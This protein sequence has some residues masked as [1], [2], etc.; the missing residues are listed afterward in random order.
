MNFFRTLCLA[1]AVFLTFAAMS[2]PTSAADK[3][4]PVSIKINESISSDDRGAKYDDPLAA[5]LKD[6]NLGDVIGGGNS[7]NKAG[8]VEWAGIDLEV[9]DLQKSIPVIK[10]KLIELGAPKGSTIEYHSGGKK[11]VVQVQ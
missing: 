8:K 10:Q 9:N 4:Y 2:A 5:A 3:V 6:A 11:I 7:V 1:C